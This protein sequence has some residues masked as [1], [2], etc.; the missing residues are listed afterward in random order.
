LAVKGKVPAPSDVALMLPAPNLRKL[1]VE[2]VETHSFWHSDP[3][4]AGLRHPLLRSTLFPI[5]EGRRKA[6]S[7]SQAVSFTLTDAAHLLRLWATN[8]PHHFVPLV[9]PFASSVSFLS[10]HKS[11]K[12]DSSCRISGEFLFA[13]FFGH[14]DVCRN[15]GRRSKEP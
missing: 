10:R 4:F 5:R 11:R 1:Q 2:G 8:R 9:L 12:N 6:G 14:V 13:I 3:S 7:Q 15:H